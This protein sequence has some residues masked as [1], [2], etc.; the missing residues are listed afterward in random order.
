MKKQRLYKEE[1][2]MRVFTAIMTIGTCLILLSTTAAAK[3]ETPGCRPLFTK[4]CLDSVPEKEYRIEVESILG[5]A[6]AERKYRRQVIDDL[7]K[8]KSSH[9]NAALKRN[10]LLE[11]LIDLFDRYL[12]V[13]SKEKMLQIWIAKREMEFFIDYF[14]WEAKLL[15]EQ[16]TL[17]ASKIFSVKDFGA[18]GNGKNDDGPA[19]RKAI[20][21]AQTLHA[22]ATV[23]FPAGNYRI[24]PGERLKKIRF[25]DRSGKTRAI[26]PIFAGQSG[27]I[28]II[29]PEHLTL[30]GEDGTRLIMTD[31]AFSGIAIT[32]GYG[33]TVKNLTI[34]YDPLPFTQGKIL[35][36][37]KDKRTVVVQID[38]GYQ[39][40][41][42]PSIA[43]A[44]MWRLSLSSQE[45]RK[46]TGDIYPIKRCRKTGDNRYEIEIGTFSKFEKTN[47]L[48]PGMICD[49]KGRRN[50]CD[51][52]AFADYYSKMTTVENVWVHSSPSV[53]YHLKSIAFVMNNSGVIRAPGSD[54]LISS[55][56]D[57]V[58]GGSTISLIGPYLE[59]C[60]FDS[61]GDDGINS[62]A[63][64]HPLKRITENG[65]RCEPMY[66][67]I[68]DN[69]YVI[70][71]NSGEIKAVARVVKKNG[72]AQ[73]D[74]P[75]PKDLTTLDL[76]KMNENVKAGDTSYAYRNDAVRLPDRMVIGRNQFGGT[77]I[78]NTTYRNVRGLGVQLTS[79]SFLVENCE[80]D[81]LTGSGIS[82]TALMSWK[83]YYSTHNAVIRNC[84]FKEIPIGIRFCCI[85]PYTS[86]KIEVASIYDIV[87]ENNSI[88][89]DVRRAFVI[90]NTQDAT[91]RNNVLIG[92]SAEKPSQ[93]NINLLWE[94]NTLQK[95]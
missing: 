39:A 78:I 86:G 24:V 41:D 93:G 11:R 88:G 83:M 22:P 65:F 19:I 69:V 92:T 13:G 57:G 33:T 25:K 32:A 95:K 5:K 16:K 44:V 56:A 61:T 82:G 77:A 6:R 53:A 63:V 54:R 3:E 79:P 49:I 50:H 35:E 43:E 10:E 12:A 76:L 52:V 94:N 28:N 9:Y 68:G 2:M 71:G 1:T 73:F 58:M 87:I 14:H 84:I 7:K 55:N 89:P 8:S 80:F 36:V 37:S 42:N 67:G 60:L 90:K 31:P 15:Q 27:H 20:E 34:D 47:N 64:A 30:S 23:F 91:V 70:D 38:K 29:R 46:Y 75:L 51:A 40:P 66:A 21:A 81:H 74:I 26:Q 59:N 62:T 4:Q 72:K 45:T 48:V 18:E 85:P 17:P